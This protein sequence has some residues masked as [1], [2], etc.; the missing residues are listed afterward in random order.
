M[1]RCLLMLAVILMS[2]G[3]GWTAHVVRQ[4]PMTFRTTL[5]PGVTYDF[6]FSVHDGPDEAAARL[7]SEGPVALT[8]RADGSITHLLG[9]IRPLGAPVDFTRQLWVQW[10]GGGETHRIRMPVV[11]YAMFA[12]DALPGPQGPR[13]ETG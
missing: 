10:R 13:G 8:V 12:V 1:K 7:W 4:I 3:F 5:I 9:R 11:P 2:P 6:S